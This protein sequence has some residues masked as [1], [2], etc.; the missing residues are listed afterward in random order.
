VK[1]TSKLYLSAAVLLLA[2][3]TFLF[4]PTAYGQSQSGVRTCGQLPD[5]AWWGKTH[6]SVLSTVEKRYKGDWDQYTERWLKYRKT[7]QTLFDQKKPAIV[8]SRG[9]RMEGETLKK[10]II[11]ID[12]RLEVIRCL[13]HNASLEETAP[14]KEASPKKASGNSTS[15]KKSSAKPK[16]KGATKETQVVSVQEDQLQLEVRA[17]CTSGDAIFQVLNKGK[18]WPKLGNVNIY[19]IKEKKVVSKRR[20]RMSEGQNARFKV[21]AK[22]ALLIGDIGLSVQPTWYDRPFKFDTQISCIE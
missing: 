14:V 13:R 16:K 22:K 12:T 17:S 19:D 1:L 21:A 11:N 5:V 20:M 2:G 7:M 10:H 8:K 15:A 3:G 18:P 6:R 4:T 9:V